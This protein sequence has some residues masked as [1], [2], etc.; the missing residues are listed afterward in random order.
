M[1]FDD[2]DNISYRYILSITYTEMGQLD[3]YNPICCNANKR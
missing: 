1:G 2:D 3:T